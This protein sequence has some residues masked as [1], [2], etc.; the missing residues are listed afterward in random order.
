[1]SSSK[2]GLSKKRLKRLRDAAERYV[3]AGQIVGAITLV[4][5]KGESFVEV[6][7]QADRERSTPLKR[8]SIFRIASM[9]KPIAAA[10]AMVL[11]EEGKLRLDEP[12][13]RLLP[14]LADRKVLVDPAGPLEDVVPAARPITL[15][16]LLTFR[17][18]FGMVFG[19]P[20]QETPIQKAMAD[21]QLIGFKPPTPHEPDEW[22]GRLGQLP[23]IHQPGERWMY[24]T[25]S[26]VLGVLIARAAGQPLEAF[27]KARI[28]EPLGMRDTG[29]SV[30]KDKLDRLTACYSVNAESRALE[31][32]DDPQDS[33]WSKPPA[34]P[35]AGGWLVSTLDDYHAFGKM[36]LNKGVL[37]KERVLSRRSVEV[38]TTDQLTPEQK[39]ASPFF[40]GF[41]ASRGWGFGVS[42]VTRRVDL[43]TT[44]GRFGWDGAFGTSWTSDPAEDMVGLLMIQRLGFGP[45]P[46]GMNADFWTLAYQAIDD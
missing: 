33:I 23:L 16:D 28:F 32:Y 13:D 37:G 30:P 39:A 45:E 14:E 3:E 11:V 12:V 7:G 36:M 41:W 42:M 10:A 15:R 40:P 1:M 5:R 22:L 9:T 31:L 20:G 26:D 38:M 34:F 46:V 24:H 21:H 35:A 44:P 19:P 18:G 17:M 8:D 43:A 2:S 4:E 25:G 6:V 29:F 27:M